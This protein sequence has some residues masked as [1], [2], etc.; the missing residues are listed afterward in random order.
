MKTGNLQFLKI[1]G[2]CKCILRYSFYRVSLQ[3]SVDQKQVF[4]L[5]QGRY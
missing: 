5:Y 2:S 4:V 3:E 1:N